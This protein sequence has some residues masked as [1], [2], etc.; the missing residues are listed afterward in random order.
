MQQ[1]LTFDA[2]SITEQTGWK[3][4]Q[5][6]CLCQ[7]FA[8]LTRVSHY[9]Y[10]LYNRDFLEYMRRRGVLGNFPRVGSDRFHLIARRSASAQDK[11]QF[12]NTESYWYAQ[13]WP[14]GSGQRYQYTPQE[15]ESFWSIIMHCKGAAQDAWELFITDPDYA[16]DVITR[17][18]PAYFA[19]RL[20]PI[21]DH[22]APPLAA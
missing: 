10:D 2:P 13:E 22:L 4:P 3:R 18:L 11:Q 20:P 14:V 7:D 15:M 5:A 6:R 19:E 21:P 16:K 17:E 1:P 8:V 9:T 12:L